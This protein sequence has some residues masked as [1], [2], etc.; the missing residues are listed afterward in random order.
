MGDGP[1]RRSD[2]AA[3]GAAGNGGEGATPALSGGVTGSG[4]T[5]GAGT[6]G[7]GGITA[8]G[9]AVVANG[10]TT[11]AGGTTSMIDA[12]Q[13]AANAG[14]RDAPDAGVHPEPGAGGAPACTSA[15]FWYQDMDGDG[16]GSDA[17]TKYQCPAP[18]GTWVRAGGDCNDG[19]ATV[20]PAQTKFFGVPYQQADNTDSFDYDC[21]GKE[22]PNPEFTIA[23]DDCG[24]LK[25]LACGSA[26]GYETNNRA[27][28][29]INA[30]CGSTTVRTCIPSAVVCTTTTK[31]GQP[32][33]S[34]R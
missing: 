5:T 7:S 27:G 19:D 1:S 8:N 4:G 32:A 3:T 34:C 20:N 25:V 18:R 31:S 26:S 13:G 12:G 6:T 2:A 10:G 16:Y 11:A 14:G 30:W 9:G 23:P 28:P 22:E 15:V 21:S 29:G 17:V 24:L 33:F